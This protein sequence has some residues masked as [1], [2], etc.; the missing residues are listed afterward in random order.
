MATPAVVASLVD[1]VL[2]ASPLSLDDDEGDGDGEA[3][4]AAA[5]DRNAGDAAAA[6]ATEGG[7]DEALVTALGQLMQTSG[8]DNYVFRAAAS[9][10]ERVRSSQVASA[11]ARPSRLSLSSSMKRCA[12]SSSFSRRVPV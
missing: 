9:A 8:P 10:M 12:T 7:G 5:G 11:S 1:K 6:S 4:A 2:A 3:A